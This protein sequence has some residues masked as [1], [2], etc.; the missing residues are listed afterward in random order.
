MR[1]RISTLFPANLSTARSLWTRASVYPVTHDVSWRMQT[2][3][4]PTSTFNGSKLSDFNLFDIFT[5]PRTYSLLF[6]GMSKK[7]SDCVFNKK[8]NGFVGR[9]PSAFRSKNIKR[10]MI[11]HQSGNI[12]GISTALSLDSAQSF[13]WGK[14]HEIMV[15]DKK[16]IPKPEMYYQKYEP[17]EM[18]V[19]VTG[20]DLDYSHERECTISG[21]HVSSC[22][23]RVQR[24]GL[25]SWKIEFNPLYVDLKM[26]PP[27]LK[28]EFR[29]VVN[30]F[31]ELI[32]TRK[33]SSDKVNEY[34]QKELNFYLKV[35]DELD[36]SEE[37]KAAIVSHFK[38][39]GIEFERKEG[40][41]ID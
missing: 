27:D 36:Y 25:L 20:D 18:G 1:T 8:M 40:P 21:A 26:L 37:H 32:Q 31:Y 39:R 35:A 7:E 16:N 28:K 38:G 9:E 29:D 3:C 34:E 30:S 22:I 14:D 4:F 23:A 33:P 10:L 15:F 13:S 11:E 2:L 6:R 41:D 24:V 5:M 17:G 12:K 19:S